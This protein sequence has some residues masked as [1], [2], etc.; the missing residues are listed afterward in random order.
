[1]HVDSVRHSHRR[2]KREFKAVFDA[3][4][5][6]VDTCHVVGMV[7][8]HKCW[9]LLLFLRTVGI[10]DTSQSTRHCLCTC[11]VWTCSIPT[12]RLCLTSRQ[13]SCVCVANHCHSLPPPTPWTKY[14]SCGN[15]VRITETF[16]LIADVYQANQSRRH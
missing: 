1:M 3:Y 6:L 4:L 11:Q 8:L 10:F 15:A 5:P 12:T 16:G 13:V 14:A 7:F 2:Q 9:P